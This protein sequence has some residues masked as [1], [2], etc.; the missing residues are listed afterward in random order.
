MLLLRGCTLEVTDAGITD[1]RCSFP[2]DFPEPQKAMKSEMAAGCL[3][4]GGTMWA[5]QLFHKS[6]TRIP[7]WGQSSFN[8]GFGDSLLVLYTPGLGEISP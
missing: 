3:R 1:T 6:A 2:L 5:V 8:E 7:V 4:R